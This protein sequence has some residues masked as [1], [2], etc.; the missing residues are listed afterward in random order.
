MDINTKEGLAEA[1]FYALLGTKGG[2]VFPTLLRIDE[3]GLDGSHTLFS[4]TQDI[5]SIIHALSRSEE[6]RALAKEVIRS[7][8]DQKNADIGAWAIILAND[9]ANLTD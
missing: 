6:L 5:I 8:E 1:A 7:C 4:D 9:V 3:P 2:M